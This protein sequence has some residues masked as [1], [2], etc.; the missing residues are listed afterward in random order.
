MKHLPRVVWLAMSVALPFVFAAAL[1]PGLPERVP[2]HFGADGRP[3][4]WSGRSNIFLGP[5]IMAFVSVFI[6]V[7]MTNIGRIDPKH[8][9]TGEENAI[10]SFAIFLTAFLS[11]LSL[12][13]IAATAWPSLPVIRLMLGSLGVGFVGIGLYLPRL[14]PN[15]FAGFRLPWTLED[16]DNWASTHRLAGRVW[17][18]GGLFIFLAA[19]LLDGPWLWAAFTLSMSVLVFVPVLHSWRHF[20]LRK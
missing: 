2:V 9:T 7:L 5:G 4:A 10:K 3:D 20:R 11:L 8:R 17:S 19:L 1:Y 16:P 6:Y 18:L 12:C 14:G 13:I 15:Y